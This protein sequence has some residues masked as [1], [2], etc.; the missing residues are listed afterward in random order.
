MENKIILI[1]L[2]GGLIAPK[3]WEA[4]TADLTVI[5]RLIREIKKSSKQVLLVSGSGNFGHKAVRK[6]GIDTPEGIRKVRKSA[7]KIGEIV[8]QEL[9]NQGFKAKLIEPNKFYAQKNKDLN[10]EKF[11]VMY[12]DVVGK[13]IWSGE[14]VIENLIPQL[15][16]KIEMVVQV[17]KEEGVWDE[18]K[19]IVPEINL[20]NWPV[21]KT[22]V[23]GV[24]GDD[25][26]GGMRH[27]VEESLEI[28]KKYGVDT[29]I[30]N[31]NIKGRLTELLMNKETV[32]TRIN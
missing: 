12:G 8:Y 28:A 1:K 29:W 3:N 32:G 17:S 20:K 15:E 21:I 13:E 11:N 24:E 2:G 18:N 23:F 6:F 26:T 22:K 27:K 4:E 5:K 19:Q 7:K 25:V 14:K 30:I 31:G 16:G 9:K 10:L